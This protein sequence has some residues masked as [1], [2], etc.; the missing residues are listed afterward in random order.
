MTLANF[1]SDC[2][3]QY[4]SHEKE[5]LLKWLGKNVNSPQIL[6]YPSEDIFISKNHHSTTY[7]LKRDYQVSKQEFIICTKYNLCKY[8]MLGTI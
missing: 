5:T 4:Q 2:C 1:S 6:T 8:M 7:Q 3:L